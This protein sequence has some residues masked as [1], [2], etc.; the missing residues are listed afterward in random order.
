MGSLAT[1]LQ[2]QNIT[3]KNIMKRSRLQ[4]IIREELASVL[5]ERN[6]PAKEKETTEAPPTTKPGTKPKRR[7]FDKPSPGVKPTP[8]NEAKE[9]ELV[10]KIA[11]RFLKHKK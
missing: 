7:G 1:N 8:K 5:A 6:A 2:Q 11:Q 9:K 10:N 3:E 4:E